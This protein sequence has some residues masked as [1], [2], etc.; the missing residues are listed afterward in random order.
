MLLIKRVRGSE[1]KADALRG[2]KGVPAS[3]RR[4]REREKTNEEGGRRMARKGYA[5]EIR[6]RKGQGPGGG[7]RIEL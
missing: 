5:D 4:E 3:L 1:E 2:G 6:G 7:R